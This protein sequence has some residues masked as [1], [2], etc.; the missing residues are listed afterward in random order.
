MV[1]YRLD[2]EYNGAH[3]THAVFTYVFLDTKYSNAPLT[4]AYENKD[5]EQNSLDDAWETI[6]KTLKY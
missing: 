1:K 2:R 5:T 4:L 6:I 3:P